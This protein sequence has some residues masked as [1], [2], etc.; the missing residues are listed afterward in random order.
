MSDGLLLGTDGLLRCAW[1]GPGAVEAGCTDSTGGTDGTDYAAYHDREWGRPVHGD[2]ALF[3]RL[4]LEAFQSGLSWLTIL[5][6]RAAF[7][8][9]F[10]G[11]VPEIVAGFDDGDVARLMNDAGIV[12]NRAKVAATV[13]N[14]RTLRD[15]RQQRGEGVLDRLVWGFADPP[16]RPAPWVP[17][18]VPATTPASRELARELK[19]A[20]FAFVGPTT[21][22]ALMQACG[23]VRDHLAGCH[24]RA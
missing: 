13:S 20:G 17:A 4:S 6:K 21:A 18:D 11:F 12:R 22:Y 15:L 3:E 19:R 7:R 10:A 24:V 1:A 14:A 8:E 9:A 2:V 23:L 5:R 16:Q